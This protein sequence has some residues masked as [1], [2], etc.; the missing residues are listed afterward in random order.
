MKDSSL[1]LGTASMRFVEAYSSWQ[2]LAAIVTHAAVY[3][4]IQLTFYAAAQSA[5]SL[6]VVAPAWFR[7]DAPPW[8]ITGYGNSTLL[9][10]PCRYIRTSNS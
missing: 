8:H 9:L 5:N 3:S 10:V 2:L 7:S 6:W 1:V 4:L